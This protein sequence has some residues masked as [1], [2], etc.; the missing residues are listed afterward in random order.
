[1]AYFSKIRYLDRKVS[2]WTPH[3]ICTWNNWWRPCIFHVYM[4]NLNIRQYLKIECLALVCSHQL[5]NLMQNILL[6]GR[7]T[8]TLMLEWLLCKTKLKKKPAKKTAKTNTR[9]FKKK[10]NSIECYYQNFSIPYLFTQYKYC[11]KKNYCFRT[12]I[13]IK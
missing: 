2:R 7:I 12:I 8:V 3:H 1:M 4:E 5:W 13:Q 6:S 10:F 9:T 11:Y